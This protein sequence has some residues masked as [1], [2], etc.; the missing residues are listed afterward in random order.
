MR[1]TL[2]TLY[3][4]L[5]D[6]LHI[7]ILNFV[8]GHGTVVQPDSIN[9]VFGCKQAQQYSRTHQLSY[10]RAVGCSAQ[11]DF[12]LV[13]HHSYSRT[14]QFSCISHEVWVTARFDVLF[15]SLNVTKTINTFLAH[16]RVFK[17]AT[18]LFNAA[19]HHACSPTSIK[20]FIDILL[21]A[22]KTFGLKLA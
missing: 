11:N 21:S 5:A 2:I 8:A 15:K 20:I 18:N 4:V 14:L 10:I 3:F 6:D 19:G 1:A 9:I 16:F 7:N 12:A 17:K 22:A 13:A